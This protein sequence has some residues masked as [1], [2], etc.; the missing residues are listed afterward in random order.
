M[1]AAIIRSALRRPVWVALLG[2][3]LLAI[4]VGSLS[5]AKYDV[6]PEFVP[7]QASVQVEAPGFSATQVE[8][9]VTQRMENAINGGTNVITVRSQSIQ[10]LSVITVLFEEGS[11]PFLDRQMLS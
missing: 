8:Q 10:G 5:G 3:L 2:L 1:L 7:P 11:D 4:G 9:L 6:F